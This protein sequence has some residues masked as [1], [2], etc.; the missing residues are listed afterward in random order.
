MMR[1]IEALR[2]HISP[3]LVHRITDLHLHIRE[4]KALQ[5]TPR[6]IE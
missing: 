1:W 4:S 3:I 2:A 6:G 5:P